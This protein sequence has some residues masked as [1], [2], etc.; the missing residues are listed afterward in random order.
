MRGADRGVAGPDGGQ[1]VA[2]IVQQPGVLPHTAYL[3]VTPTRGI[4]RNWL[5]GVLARVIRGYVAAG[6]TLGD[7]LDGGFNGRLSRKLLATVDETREGLT[8]KRYE[9]GNALQRI[10]TEETRLINPKY[11]M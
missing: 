3:M 8:A 2:H 9:R 7:V 11:G 10:V 4:G 6:V 1:W 5:T